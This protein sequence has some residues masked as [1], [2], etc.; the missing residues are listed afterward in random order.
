V[1]KGQ[2]IGRLGNSGNTSEPH[3][4]FHVMTSPLPLTA[5]NVPFVIDRFD[6]LGVVTPDG[7]VANPTAGPRTAE[8]PL[9]GSTAIYSRR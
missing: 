7:V 2:E 1:R 6:H 5:D 4:H 3:V 8:L 9:A